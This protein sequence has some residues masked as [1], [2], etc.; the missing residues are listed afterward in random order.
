MVTCMYYG[1]IILSVV[2]FSGGFALNDVYQKRRGSSIK[3]S[4]QFS[5]ISSFAGLIVLLAVN[6]WRLECTVFTFFMALLSALN[7]FGFVFCGFKA[8]GWINLSL[9]SL[10]SMLGGMALPFLQGLLFYG[11][12]ITAAKLICFGFICAALIVTV[13]KGDKSKGAPYYIG[14]FILNG[15]AGVLAKI[16]ACAPFEKT[17]AAGYTILSAL[18]TVGIS[19]VLLLLFFRKQ[20]EAPRSAPVS[21]GVGALYGITNRIANLVLVL[22]LAHVDASIQYPMVTGGVMIVSTLI[23]LFSKNKP[24]KKEGASVAL[25][26]IGMAALFAVPI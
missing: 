7:G 17:S 16:F 18:C 3:V 14:I 12:E 1:L 2:L 4:L 25:A 21:L 23:C 26:F 9:Y 5:L 8:L 13:E 15:M 22:A 6:A 19:A 10:F 20:R 11:E 24:S